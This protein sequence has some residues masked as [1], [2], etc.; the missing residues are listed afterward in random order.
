MMKT[1]KIG[2][3]GVVLVLF[4]LSANA[5]GVGESCITDADCDDTVYCNGI[6]SCSSEGSVCVA[7]IPVDCGVQ[8]CD[9]VSQGCVDCVTDGD[10]DDGE[11]CNGAEICDAGGECLEGVPVDC[12]E[13]FCSAALP[14]EG[15]A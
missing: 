10:C 4:A 6:E 1:I 2:I 5:A 15:V 3:I 14:L 11:Y 13:G 12:G 9:E 7:G 8:I